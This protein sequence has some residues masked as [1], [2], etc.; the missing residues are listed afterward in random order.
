LRYPRAFSV[1]ALDAQ[2]LDLDDGCALAFAH[3]PCL[4]VCQL[5]HRCH[6]RELLALRRK[7]LLRRLLPRSD[8]LPTLLL[9]FGSGLQTLLRGLQTLLLPLSRVCFP[10]AAKLP[11]KQ[12]LLLPCLL[13]VLPLP[14]EPRRTLSKALR[15]AIL[16][17][18][19]LGEP[20]PLRPFRPVLGARK[21]IEDR[22]A[23]DRS[24][25]HILLEQRAVQ[26]C[27]P[28]HPGNVG[29]VRLTNLVE[30]VLEPVQRG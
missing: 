10:H 24:R 4:I 23:A 6:L 26:P 25:G 12:K 2:L 28:L 9:R 17:T 14:L 3:L 18:V 11:G 29:G 5:Q 8:Q 21:C 30:E 13:P 19:L 15:S 7:S 16:A 1:D 27:V 22:S 20:D